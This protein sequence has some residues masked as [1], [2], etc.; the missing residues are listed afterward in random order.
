MQTEGGWARGLAVV[1][2]GEILGS[3]RGTEDIPDREGSSS[4][5][6]HGSF[7][8]LI[9]ALGIARSSLSSLLMRS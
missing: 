5:E 9:T 7:Q 4:S 8:I 1:G 3:R 2:V 6:L